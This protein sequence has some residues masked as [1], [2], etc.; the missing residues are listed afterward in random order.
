LLNYIFYSF[1]EKLKELWRLI[2][3]TELSQF[4]RKDKIY[5]LYPLRNLLEDSD[6]SKSRF[7]MEEMAD[8]GEAFGELLEFIRKDLEVIGNESKLKDIVRI[9]IEKHYTCICGKEQVFPYDNDCMMLI[10]MADTLRAEYKIERGDD[11][12]ELMR[13]Q[14]RLPQI[15]QH[16]LNKGLDFHQKEHLKKCRY[17]PKDWDKKLLRI[18]GEGGMSTPRVSTPD[19]ISM[20]LAWQES[21][22]M[23]VLSILNMIPSQFN[24]EEMFE[25][26]PGIQNKKYFFR[27]M[28]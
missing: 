23:D 26:S 25:I 2:D 22:P 16:L 11:S 18:G 13:Q 12:Y 28:I 8:A 9:P 14:G 7:N 10:V 1:V 4:I 27:G 5:D 17:K 21:S 15:L 19:V 20:N 3:T 6:N 24:L